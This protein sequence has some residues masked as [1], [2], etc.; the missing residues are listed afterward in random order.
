M[1]PSMP[2]P[3]VRIQLLKTRVPVKSCPTEVVSRAAT[4]N[5]QVSF[6]LA[7]TMAFI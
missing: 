7:L 2:L 6:V 4:T 5:A 1:F 3:E